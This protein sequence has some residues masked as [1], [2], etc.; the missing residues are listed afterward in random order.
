MSA[1]I[2]TNTVESRKMNEESSTKRA[3]LT[4]S[5][6]F[7]ASLTALSYVYMSFPE[8]AEE[9]K[10]YMKLPFH[11]EDAK[12]LGKLLGRY[13]DLYYFEVLAGL[14]VTYIFLQTFAIPG[15]IFL[16]ILS[17]FLFPFPIALLLVCTCSAVG[18]TLC[19]LLSSLLGRKLLYKYFPEKANEWTVMVAKHKD[20]LLNYMLF[21]RITPLLPNWFI[22][23]ASPVIGVPIVPFT[24]GT[25]FGVAPPSF[26]AIQAGQTLHNLTSSSDAWSWNSMIILCIFAL[27][28]LVPVL[29]KQKLKEKFE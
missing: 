17:G 11:I 29:C 18:A 15:S 10:Q 2:S 3:I 24:V 6:V 20:H 28:S 13:K 5:L 27:L 25:F 23:L 22:N 8:L 26:V 4:V 21:L 14:F 1:R 19:Y 7:V 12:N 16:S 9:E